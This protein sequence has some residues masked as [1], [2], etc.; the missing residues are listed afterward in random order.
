V[1]PSDVFRHRSLL[2]LTGLMVLASVDR[3]ELHD[4]PWLPVTPL[5]LAEATDEGN[6]FFS[7]LRQRDLLVHHPYE[8]FSSSV[9]EFLNQAADDPSVL[10][11]KMTL[12]R[13]SGDSPIVKHLIRAAERGTQVAVLVELKARFDEQRNIAWAK[14]LER[15]GVHVVYGLVGLKTH[16]KSVL[17]VREEADGIRRYCHLGTGNYHSSTA[18]IYEDLGLFTCDPDIGADLTQLFNYL[19]GFSREARYRRL[20]VA[21]TWLRHQL[22]DLVRGEAKYGREGRIVAKMNSLSDPE[23]IEALYDASQAG[24]EIKLVVRGICCL[25]PGVEGLSENISVRSI[26]GRNL[27]HSRIYSFAN[28]N[29][30]GEAAW[31]IGSAD[32]MP[33][34]LNAR[35][36]ALTPIASPELQT[37]LRQILDLNLGDDTTVWTLGPDGHWTREPKRHGISAQEQ[38]KNLAVGRSRERL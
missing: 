17:V 18:R 8:S 9:E 15:A 38:L 19:T 14:A 33:R 25:R 35:V 22:L 4:E 20:L 2:D 24:V 36:E 11:I 23:M 30:P 7:V 28:G 3:D 26:V 29:G 13:T 16:I 27:E 6:S 37:R 1:E 21:P 31:F 12:Y 32:M 10:T 5:S 34:N